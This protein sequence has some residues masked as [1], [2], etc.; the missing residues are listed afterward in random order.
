MEESVLA[1]FEKLD[2]RYLPNGCIEK[3]ITKESIAREFTKIEQLPTKDSIYVDRK[4]RAQVAQWTHAN[5]RK[6]FATMILCHFEAQYLLLAMMK[7]KQGHFNDKKL[8]LENPDDIRPSPLIFIPTIWVPG[9]LKLFYESQWKFLAPTF[10]TERYKTYDENAQCIL[11]FTIVSDKPRS[12]AFG[13]VSKVR[14]HADHQMD[15]SAQVVAIKEITIAAGADGSETENAWDIEA[16]ALAN[17]NMLDHPHI[18][19]C[20]AAIRRG[21]SRYFMFPW[22][23]GGN[24]RDLW[25]TMQNQA[26]SPELVRW[27]LLQIKGLADALVAMHHSES[28]LVVGVG[29]NPQRNGVQIP[30][31]QVFDENDEETPAV[32]KK[33]IRHGD[34][35]PENLLIFDVEQ[36]GQG[37]L[38]IADMGLAKQHIE[39]TGE[40]KFPTSTRYGTVRYEP[41]EAARNTLAAR[42]RLYDIWSMGCIV[43]EFIIWI[44]YGNDLLDVFY[45]QMKNTNDLQQ[46]SQFFQV[47]STGQSE[48]HRVVRRWI[49]QIQ[50]HDPACAKNS[51]IKDLLNVVR[52]KLLVIHLR[53]DRE[54]NIGDR[55]T[56]RLLALPAI[57]DE[58]TRYRATAKQFRDAMDEIVMKIKDSDYLSVGGERVVMKSMLSRVGGEDGGLA[59]VIERPGRPLTLGG[60]QSPPISGPATPGGY[61]RRDYTLP[62]LKDWIYTRDDDFAKK[63]MTKVRGTEIST[64]PSQLCERCTNLN[65][66]EAGFSIRDLRSNLSDK[67]N[68]C[69]LCTLLL[70]AINKGSSTTEEAVVFERRH[71]HLFLPGYPVPALSIVRTNWTRSSAS[72]QLGFP[73]LLSPGTREFYTIIKMWLEDCDD[74]IRTNESHKDCHVKEHERLPTRL[75]DVGTFEDPR[76]RLVGT[77]EAKITS[78]HYIALSHPWGDTAKYE[79]FRTLESNEETFRGAIPEDD[80]PA[81]FKDAVDCTRRLGI[82]YLWIDSICIIQDGGDFKKEAKHMEA[83]FSGAYCVLAASR[84]INQKSGFLKSRDQREFVKINHDE[85]ESFYICDFIDNFN[86]HVIQGSLNKRGWV[87]QER[88]L[89]R[90][91]IYFTETQTYFECGAGV[92]CET[93]T[94][95]HNHMAAFLGDPKFP[96]RTLKNRGSKIACFQGLYEQYSRLDFTRQEDRPVAIAGLEQRLQ[97]AFGTKGAY[98]IFDD[99]DLKDDGLFGRS[100]LWQRGSGDGCLPSLEPI[101]F[102]SKGHDRVP[103]WSWMAYQGGID[104]AGPP[105]GL[106]CWETAELKAP[107]TRL[108]SQAADSAP[109]HDEIALQAV[110]RDYS[111]GG[112]QSDEFELTWDR[113]STADTNSQIAQCCVVARAKEATTAAELRYDVLIVIA[114]HVSASHGERMYERVGAGWMLGKFIMWNEPGVAAKIV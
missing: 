94:N 58:V 89:A 24:L 3:L 84:A 80:L 1:T 36:N 100:L 56:G 110:V 32:N 31:V 8:P 9:K 51:A 4:T 101:D 13:S 69:K 60:V 83:V 6:V 90:R 105:F 46:I 111:I 68:R 59:P 96:N 75:I 85:D 72:C 15:K 17:I 92:R 40:R 71:S 103:S 86:E 54:S 22:A 30:A 2:R 67:A 73:T 7:L 41:P 20:D 10:G 5:A 16:I 42:S 107:W 57:G 37:T 106:V 95:L 35:K 48:I 50:Q 44:L 98:G 76:L 39:M 66:W 88:V 109:Q 28:T 25:A 104:Y 87:F 78:T 81:T 99:G 34:L 65:F 49:N 93:M 55:T 114:K 91:T 14:I 29:P 61:E 33:N 26:P 52:E 62:P 19:R 82:P 79:T 64:P 38:K 43:L 74:P 102:R 45:D 47:D 108:G 21:E 12:G 18:I 112:A 70:T 77:E 113:P 63:V 11:P 53:P 97:R 23:E 27:A